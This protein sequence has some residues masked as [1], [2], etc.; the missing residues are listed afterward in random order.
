MEGVGV[1]LELRVWT[2]GGVTAE[3]RLNVIKRLGA[4]VVP[5]GPVQL[6]Q[7][8]EGVGDVGVVG[9]QRF[10]SDAE[11][12]LIIRLGPRIVPFGL[13]QPR[14]VVEGVGDVGVVG[15]QRFLPDTQF[16]FRTSD[17]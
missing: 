16:E 7:V 4:R 2:A 3:D 13:I 14:Q 1:K 15:P 6:C 10:L 11:G 8:I 9:P 12:A 17:A 5:F